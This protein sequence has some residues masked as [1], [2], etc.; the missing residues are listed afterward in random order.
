VKKRYGSNVARCS[1]CG[2]KVALPTPR[3]SVGPGEWVCSSCAYKREMT[4]RRGVVTAR[5]S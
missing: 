3:V 4:E 5:G 1:D 2:G